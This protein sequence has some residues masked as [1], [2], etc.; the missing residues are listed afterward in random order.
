MPARLARISQP[1]QAAGGRPSGAKEAAQGSTVLSGQI[2]SR[3][4]GSEAS[5][6]WE[7]PAASREAGSRIAARIRSYSA[8]TSCSF[9]W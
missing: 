8:H 1:S 7:K 2:H 6:G 4:T 3:G 9:E 5:Q